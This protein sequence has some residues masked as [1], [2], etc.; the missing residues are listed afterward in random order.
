MNRRPCG[1]C[2]VRRAGHGGSCRLGLYMYHNGSWAMHKAMLGVPASTTVAWARRPPPL[3]EYLPASPSVPANPTSTSH[4]T[5]RR[6]AV[7]YVVI[8]VAETEELMNTAAV[9]GILLERPPH[10][11]PLPCATAWL[12][13]V[14]H[15]VASTYRLPHRSPTRIPAALQ[16]SLPPQRPCQHASPSLPLAPGSHRVVSRQLTR[17]VHAS[18]PLLITPCICRSDT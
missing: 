6:R 8:H 3:D 15:R 11:G 5:H 18:T 13:I 14:P 4:A 16:R 9:Y 2:C 10:L 17:V 7:P 12:P 1:S